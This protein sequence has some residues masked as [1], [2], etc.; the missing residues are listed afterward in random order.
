[1]TISPWRPQST[2]QFTARGDAEKPTCLFYMYYIRYASSTWVAEWMLIIITVRGSR[3]LRFGRL[4]S[5]SVPFGC[6]RDRP[7]SR[8]VL[9]P[10]QNIVCCFMF[11]ISN[12]VWMFQ[13]VSWCCFVFFLYDLYSGLP[14]VLS[15]S[16]FLTP[17]WLLHNSI[18]ELRTLYLLILVYNNKIH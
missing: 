9:Y 12:A 11:E 8:H 16:I 13:N 7:P 14:I 15:L 17:D 5:R 18:F 4:R 2:P 1:M 3:M 10:S 6:C